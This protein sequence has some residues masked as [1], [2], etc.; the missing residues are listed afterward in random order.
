MRR[1]NYNLKF[2]S[3]LYSK[4]YQHWTP[5]SCDFGRTNHRCRRKGVNFLQDGPVAHYNTLCQQHYDLLV[6]FNTSDEAYTELLS[7]WERVSS[8][9]RS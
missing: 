7:E 5:E 8:R 3:N 2:N 1:M 9:V 6:N 4:Q